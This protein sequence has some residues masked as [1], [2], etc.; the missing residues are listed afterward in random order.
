MKVYYIYLDYIYL[1]KCRYVDN[2]VK[3]I[4]IF[5][6][7]ISRLKKNDNK[8]LLLLRIDEKD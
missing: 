5:K 2:F 6:L 1:D 8:F 4:F 3:N 7:L